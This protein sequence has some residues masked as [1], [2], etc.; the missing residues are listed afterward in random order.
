MS[1]LTYLAN[2]QADLRLKWAIAQVGL[3]AQAFTENE[4]ELSGKVEALLRIT[5]CRLLLGDPA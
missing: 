2:A 1:G 5:F 3:G 4:S